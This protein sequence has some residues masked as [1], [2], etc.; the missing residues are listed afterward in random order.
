MT[1]IS[2]KRFVNYRLVIYRW[3]SRGFAL[4]EREWPRIRISHSLSAWVR[5]VRDWMRGRAVRGVNSAAAVVGVGGAGGRG[6]G[7]ALFAGV[8]GAT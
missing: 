3:L 2:L 4:V 8:E 5:S 7:M 6:E 1:Q